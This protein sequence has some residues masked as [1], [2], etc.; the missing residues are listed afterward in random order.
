MKKYSETF[1]S[2]DDELGLSQYED[3]QKEPTHTLPP[4]SPTETV[5][6]NNKLHK[7]Q[8][9][10]SSG[11]N[12]P[13]APHPLFALDEELAFVFAPSKKTLAESAPTKTHLPPKQPVHNGVNGSSMARGFPVE[14]SQSKK[15][16]RTQKSS[17]SAISVPLEFGVSTPWDHHKVSRANGSLKL[18]QLLAQSNKTE[19]DEDAE[20]SSSPRL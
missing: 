8:S 6:L 2:C 17:R 15:I 20:D 9:A 5:I 19:G 4:T 13:E 12:S 3:E 1:F 18:S 16:N 14:V 11:S 10:S 7:N